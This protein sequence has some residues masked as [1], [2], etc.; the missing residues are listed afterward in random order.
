M[1]TTGVVNSQLLNMFIGDAAS[2]VK[3]GRML[4]CSIDIQQTLRD[5]TSK[6]D[7]RWMSKAF[8]QLNMTGQGSFLLTY[9]A[10]YGGGTAGTAAGYDEL[11]AAMIAETP[12]DITFSTGETGDPFITIPMLITQLGQTSE[13]P[14][15]NAEVSFSFEIS[16]EPT[17]GTNT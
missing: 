9:D 7:G 6:D 17:L 1:A 14:F 4:S 12:S 16:G 15:G 13:S 8:G 10:S 2:G 11:Y 5:T 3:I